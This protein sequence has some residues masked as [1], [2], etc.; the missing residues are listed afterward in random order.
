MDALKRFFLA[1]F[2][3]IAA[4]SLILKMF[5][6]LVLHL[7]TVFL[8]FKISGAVGGIVS[9]I[10]PGIAQIYWIYRIWDTV[11]IFWSYLTL[12]TAAY[13]LLWLVLMI[14]SGVAIS[15]AAALDD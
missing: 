4:I 7:Y 5:C 2:S 15:I 10:F 8:A 9:F 3:S 11:G 12:A 14:I 1:I 13:I 6:G